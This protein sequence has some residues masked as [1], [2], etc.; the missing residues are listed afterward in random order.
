MTDL[1]VYLMDNAHSMAILKFSKR[2][3][4]YQNGEGGAIAVHAH[5]NGTLQSVYFPS[6]TLNMTVTPMEG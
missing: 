1:M 5:G 6:E 2:V 3:E 4:I